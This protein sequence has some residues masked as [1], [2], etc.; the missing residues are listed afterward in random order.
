M[1]LSRVYLAGPEVFLANAREIGEKKKALCRKYGF[2]GVFPIDVE[3]DTKGK[4]AREIGLCI[5]DLNEN[6]IKSCDIVIANITPFRG[7][8]ADVG[9]VYEMGFA[10]ALGKIVY[11]YTNDPE[12]F[13]QRTIKALNGVV[14]REFDGRLRDRL[15]M[16]IEENGLIDNLMIDGCINA[17]SKRLV[18]EEAPIGERFTFLG[19]FEKCLVAAKKV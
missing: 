6:L 10:H 11:A 17:N 2:E 7:P 3:V 16:F 1:S 13:T 8:S 18:V 19:G 15:G 9:T 5:S 4:S 12:S 14:S